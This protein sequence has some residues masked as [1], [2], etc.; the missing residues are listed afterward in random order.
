MCIAFRTVQEFR[1]LVE[2][3]LRRIKQRPFDSSMAGNLVRPEARVPR[4]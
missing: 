1:A 3:D 2:S 4:Q